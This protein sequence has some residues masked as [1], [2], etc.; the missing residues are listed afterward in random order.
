MLLR[1]GKISSRIRVG[2]EPRSK[3]SGVVVKSLPSRQ[4]GLDASASGGSKG[5]TA[6]LGW[7]DPSC[8][9]L[10]LGARGKV[11]SDKAAARI[12]GSGAA[13]VSS[14]IF[15]CEGGSSSATASS[16]SPKNRGE[17][18]RLDRSRNSSDSLHLK[19]MPSL[20]TAVYDSS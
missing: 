10:C 18:L 11:N 7:V 13:R 5:L 14:H 8:F 9:K 1:A 17:L 15:L 16:A 6:E 19:W 12:A 2:L 4:R 20:H 3:R